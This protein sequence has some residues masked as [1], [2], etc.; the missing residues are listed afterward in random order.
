M[1]TTTSSISSSSSTATLSS[2]YQT[3]V[4]SIMTKESEPLTTLTGQRDSATVQKG[5]YTDLLTNLKNLQTQVEALI[6]TGTSYA[7]S[8]SK[9]A[10]VSNQ[11]DSGNVFTASASDDALVGDYDVS[12]TTLAKN[13]RVSSDQQSSS[14][15]ALGYAGTIVVGGGA[16]RGATAVSSVAGTVDGFGTTSAVSSGTTELASGNYYL[17]MRNDS[18]SGWQFRMV[19]AYGQS[20]NVKHADG[21]YSGTW[22]SVTAGTYDTGRGLTVTFGSDPS[23]YQAMSKGNGA[24]QVKYSA[25]GT[26]ITIDATKSLNDI[27]KLINSATYVAGNEIQAAVIDRQL[28]LTAK[29]SGTAHAIEASGSI[30]AKPG[31]PGQRWD[32]Q[33]RVERCCRCELYCE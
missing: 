11:T 14:S 33:P 13:H 19:D 6:S 10:T 21:T 3:L 22:Q 9:S 16:T 15:E 24:A 7:I 8:T 1:A 28:V 27:A 12:V 29:N 4:N 26:S 23:S 18:T 30:L 2:T 5:V 17:E 25:E 31:H 20:V 32:I